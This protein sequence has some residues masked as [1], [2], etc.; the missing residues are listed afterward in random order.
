[1][2]DRH[3][4]FKLHVAGEDGIKPPKWAN[5]TDG[6]NDPYKSPWSMKIL[7]GRVPRGRSHE[8]EPSA[9]RSSAL[10]IRIFIEATPCRT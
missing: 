7:E 10:Q 5:F 4:L 6:P 8:L 2:N 9:S 3:D 1:M